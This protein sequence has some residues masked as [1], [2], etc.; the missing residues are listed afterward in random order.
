MH[1]AITLSK[2][3]YTVRPLQKDD[4]EPIR[5]WRNAQMDILRQE[6]QLS[7]KDQ[8]IYWKEVLRPSFEQQQPQQ[9][10]FAFLEH[11]DLIGYGGVTHLDW[12]SKLGEV[13]F[14]L[15]PVYTKNDQKYRVL[16]KHFLALIKT[17]A[18]DKLGLVRLFTET[19]DIRPSHIA[20]LES[21]GFNLE[22]R[23]E[24][25]VEIEN[26]QVDSLIHGCEANE[27]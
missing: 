21:S 16:F 2:G 11:D 26:K 13:S 9:V 27:R 17:A 1:R 14:L 5:V 15:N 18:F 6:R 4:M 20:E 25:A 8:E 23:I 12:K 19:Y 24:N 3:A 10:L 22:K 7:E